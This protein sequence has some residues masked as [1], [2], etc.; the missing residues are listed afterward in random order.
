[1]VIFLTYFRLRIYCLLRNRQTFLLNLVLF[2]NNTH[3]VLLINYLPCI[4]NLCI[5]RERCLFMQTVI[6]IFTIKNIS[7]FYTNS[8]K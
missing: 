1:M 3:D 5:T 2:F 7:V 8:D 4:L 6:K